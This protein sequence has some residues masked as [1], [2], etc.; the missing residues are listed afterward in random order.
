M[1]GLKQ[2]RLTRPHTET[3]IATATVC[4]IARNLWRV[5]MKVL[6]VGAFAA[7]IGALTFDRDGGVDK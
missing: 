7:P 2:I 1:L 3:G 4:Q 6:A 5:I